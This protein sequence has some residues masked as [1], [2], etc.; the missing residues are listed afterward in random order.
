MYFWYK[1]I[2]YL[3][4]ISLIRF[5]FEC[6]S[7]FHLHT[8]RKLH[9]FKYLET[10]LKHEK[11]IS[12]DPKQ[13]LNPIVF[14]F[15]ITHHHNDSDAKRICEYTVSPAGLEFPPFL[16][17]KWGRWAK[18]LGCA[19]DPPVCS[20]LVWEDWMRTQVFLPTYPTWALVGGTSRPAGETVC[21]QIKDFC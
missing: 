1:I 3:F 10:D 12:N 9:W 11:M 19:S 7:N 17:P 14:R 15:V 16:G 18:K 2:Q 13:R 6:I 21:F 20:L 4:K 8:R 5:G